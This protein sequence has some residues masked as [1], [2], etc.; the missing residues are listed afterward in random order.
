MHWRT[1]LA[2]IQDGFRGLVHT[3]S[4]RKMGLP[5]YVTR[6]GEC[7]CYD[8]ASPFDPGVDMHWLSTF[9]SPAPIVQQSGF[10]GSLGDATCADEYC[11]TKFRGLADRGGGLLRRLSSTFENDDVEMEPHVRWVWFVWDALPDQ[12]VHPV[13]T[14]SQESLIVNIAESSDLACDWLSS[15][16]D[17]AEPAANDAPAEANE[18]EAGRAC[19]APTA[20]RPAVGRTRLPHLRPHDRLAY[21]LSLVHGMSQTRVAEELNREHGTNYCQGN[22]SRMVSRAKAHADASGLTEHLPTRGKA[23]DSIDPAKIDL[24]SRTDGLSERQRARSD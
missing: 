12:H 10:A 21:Q 7:F 1:E 17:D 5:I 15:N 14:N 4:T 3:L 13:G 20:E 9:G 16:V 24:G 22:I 19:N 23:A 11:L 6:Y 8:S 2:Q 18:S